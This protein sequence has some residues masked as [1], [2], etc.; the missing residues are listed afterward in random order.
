MNNDFSILWGDAG[1]AVC[2]R[3]DNVRKLSNV[4]ERQNMQ[5]TL[6]LQQVREVGCQVRVYMVDSYSEQIL[7]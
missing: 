2:F 4:E 5:H 3:I 6:H 7:W 1:C